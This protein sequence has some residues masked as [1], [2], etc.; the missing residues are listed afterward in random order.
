MWPPGS[1]KTMILLEALRKSQDMDILTLN[2]SKDTTPELLMKSLLQFCE[3]KNTNGS[4]LTLSPKINGKWVVV[5]CDEINLP[6]YDKYGTQTV[7][8]L[9]RQMIEQGGFWRLSDQQWVTLSNVQFVGACNPPTDAGRNPLSERF[10]R[11]ASLIMV[12]YPGKVSLKQIYQTYNMAVMKCAPNLRGFTQSITEAML[13]I[14]FKSKQRLTIEL[15]S[16]YIYSPR[17]LTRW[18]KGLLEAM[19]SHQYE[20]LDELVRLW[21]HEGLRLFY[22]RLVNEEEKVWTLNLFQETI[23]KVFPHLETESITTE[24]VLFSNWLSLDYEYISS[25]GELVSFVTERLRVFSEEEIDV[26]LI[27]YD[28][29][30][31]HALRIDR[32]LRQPQGHL[33]LVGPSTSGK[34]TLS[35]FVAWLNGQKVV[36]LNVFSGYTLSDFDSTLRSILLRCVSGERICFMIDESSVLETSFIERMNTLLA[37]AEIPGLFEDENLHSLMKLCQVELQTQGLYLDTDDE[38]YRWFTSQVAQN[39]HVIFTISDTTISNSTSTTSANR[40]KI[41]TSPALFNRCVLSW[42]GDWSDRSLFSMASSLVVNV[43][44]DLSN[45]VI[46]ISFE[47]IIN[48]PTNEIVDIRGVVVDSLVYIHRSI[49]RNSLPSLFLQLVKMF[50]KLFGEKLFN[51]EEN[52]RHINN[53]LDKLKETV[54]QVNEL[55]VELSEKSKILTQKDNDAKVMLNKM[56]TDQNEAERKQEFSIETQEEL[57]KQQIEIER[58]RSNVMKDLE[59]AE[60]AVL[61]ARKGVQNIKKQH[62]TE[63]R[64]MANPPNGVKITMESVCI[65]LGYDVQSWR[66]VQLVVRRDDFITNIV[67]FDNEEQLTTELRQYMVDTYLSRSDYNFEAANRASKACGP[68]LQWVEAQLTY[69]SIL[70]RIG[71]LRKE[72][73][74]LEES[75]QKTKAQLIAIDQMIKELEESIES[76]KDDYS[77]LIRDAEN[78][79][80]DMKT[81]TNKVNRSLKLIE[82]LTNERERWQMSIKKFGIERELLVGDSI[83]AA[84]FSTYCGAYDERS[85]EGLVNNWKVRLNDCAIKYDNLLNFSQYLS[86]GKEVLELQNKGGDNGTLDNLNIE[87]FSLMKS[88]SIP[89]IIDPQTMLLNR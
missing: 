80:S 15:Q 53:G 10:L 49:G 62:L 5:F 43:P 38:L 76:Y 77:Q 88:S 40:P 72:M 4:G 50:I 25:K 24:P 70:E 68:L 42:M 37:N 65:L 39:L 52:Q 56:L 79:K 31:D 82:S 55:K 47:S 30:L 2:F 84:A 22:D 87:N 33:I 21:Y 28:E 73:L 59:M 36:Q 16:H 60:P 17:E 20:S 85:R 51:L 61:E 66:D 7:I 48:N 78:V 8:S 27:L 67:S 63:I 26:D 1:G 34:S 45:Y 13:E 32:V 23:L 46:P 19:K 57:N 41:T 11:H 35:R 89:F 74:I 64:S 3:Y 71:P 75:T 29:M 58:R 12:D 18:S 6:G 54:L 81:V 69:S 86:N 83:L 44:L 14:Y 9:L